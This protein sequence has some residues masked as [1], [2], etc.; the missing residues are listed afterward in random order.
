MIKPSIH[1]LT[2]PQEAIVLLE[3]IGCV[4]VGFLASKDPEVL[5]EEMIQANNHLQFSSYNP[6]LEEVNQWIDHAAEEQEKHEVKYPHHS[7]GNTPRYNAIELNRT[8]LLAD[9]LKVAAVAQKLSP[10]LINTNGFA[11]SDIPV[12]TLLCDCDEDTVI[13]MGGHRILLGDFSDSDLASNAPT[14][15]GAS[16]DDPAS[17]PQ[18]KSFDEAS[19]TELQEWATLHTDAVEVNVGQKVD[20]QSRRHIKGVPH[21]HPMSIR[22]PA[23]FTILLLTLFIAALIT[24]PYLLITREELGEGNIAII[25]LFGS[26]MITFI[27]QSIS[28]TGS[29]CPVCLQKQFTPMSCNKHVK[30][31]RIPFMGPIVSTALHVLLFHWFYCIYCGVSIRLKKID[32]SHSNHL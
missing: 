1:T 20:H 6:K 11:V 24:I 5:L 23:F 29:T 12:A 25:S 17:S 10:H 14:L 15:D 7:T 4:Q 19:N 32:P 16:L 13:N 18:F 28:A 8:Y 21:S 27:I 22:I 31:H 30:A 3:A 2:I 9:S 26:L